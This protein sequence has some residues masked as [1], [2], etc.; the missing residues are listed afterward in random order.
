MCVEGAFAEG[1][2]LGLG[3]GVDEVL[4]RGR[5]AGEMR[6][7]LSLR[8]ELGQA[9]SA[10]ERIG[11]INNNNRGANGHGSMAW[12]GVKEREKT[13]LLLERATS[14]CHSTQVDNGMTS[15]HLHLIYDLPC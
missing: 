15:V 5:M 10:N 9:G 11:G 3:R 6:L 14:N 12:H 2:R 4:G 7:H 1:H 13:P 8:A